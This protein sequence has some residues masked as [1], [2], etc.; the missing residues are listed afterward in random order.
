MS[1]LMVE[2]RQTKNNRGYDYWQN[3]KQHLLIGSRYFSENIKVL[4]SLGS[5][6]LPLLPLGIPKKA[7]PKMSDQS[8]HVFNNMGQ[9]KDIRKDMSDM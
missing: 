1:L 2:K 7:C 5:M 3:K 8:L 4:K 6:A 9:R